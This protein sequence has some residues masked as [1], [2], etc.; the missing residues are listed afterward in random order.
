M[1]AR[2]GTCLRNEVP[3][4]SDGLAPAGA[5]YQGL[6]RG[7]WLEPSSSSCEDRA[8]RG[9]SLEAGAGATAI[10]VHSRSRADRQGAWHKTDERSA[11][12]PRKPPLGSTAPSSSEIERSERRR[13]RRA[14]GDDQIP[15]PVTGHGSVLYLGRA[16]REQPH[17]Q[18]LAAPV[19]APVR[20]AL[21][22]PGAQ[23]ARELLAERPARLHEQRLVDRL[24]ATKL[25]ADLRSGAVLPNHRRRSSSL[26]SPSDRPAAR[27]QE[28][29]ESGPARRRTLAY[30]SR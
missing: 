20:P 5:A 10:P 26:M 21:G 25:M 9:L 16:R 8:E 13:H 27:S 28:W 14:S 24:T 29:P 1:G 3:G 22:A 12:N 18:E 17:I 19:G 4:V 23:A 2:R 11:V 15:L 7:A 30:G 6:P